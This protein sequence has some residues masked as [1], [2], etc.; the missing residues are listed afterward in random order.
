MKL[1]QSDEDVPIL[2]VAN[3]IPNEI[4]NSEYPTFPTRCRPFGLFE[5]LFDNMADNDAW[6]TKM[7]PYRQSI[8]KKIHTPLM[9]EDLEYA[10]SYRQG[11]GNGFGKD[12]HRLHLD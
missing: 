5:Q 4:L 1:I 9:G 8:P 10:I 3:K 11:F 2:M 7:I 6:L 12:T